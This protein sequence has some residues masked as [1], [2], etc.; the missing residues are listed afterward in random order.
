METESEEHSWKNL[1]KSFGFENFR[2]KYY[3]LYLLK[4]GENLYL[5]QSQVCPGHTLGHCC[6]AMDLEMYNKN[7]KLFCVLWFPR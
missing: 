5:Q 4:V 2:K 6:L 3:L 1:K 7:K